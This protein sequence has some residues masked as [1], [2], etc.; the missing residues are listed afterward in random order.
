[1]LVLEVDFEYGSN[2]GES[3]KFWLCWKRERENAGSRTSVNREFC[4]VWWDLCLPSCARAQAHG[5]KK[6]GVLSF[7]ALLS[8]LEKEN[9]NEKAEQVHSETDYRPC[10]FC[11]QGP[12][13]VLQM[14]VGEGMLGFTW[15]TICACHGRR[16]CFGQ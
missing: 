1:M 7:E 15:A 16:S 11:S 4:W 3:F 13:T 5:Q 12:V 8:A 14:L 6:P 9:L 10:S 2:L